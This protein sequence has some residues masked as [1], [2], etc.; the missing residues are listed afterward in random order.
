M[1]LLKNIFAR[2]WALWGIVT[3]IISF[4]IVY[5]PSMV[6]YLIPG[7]KGQTIFIYISR[8]WMNVWLTLIGCSVKIVG[9]ENVK[10]G[11]TYIF[12]CNHNTLLD[13]PLTCPYVPGANKTIAKM[14]FAK[15]PLFGWYYAK[16]SIL[17]DR[18]SDLSRRKGFDKMKSTLKEK[19]HVC[20]Y[21]EGTRNRTN[22]P[23][24]SFYDG[25]FKLSVDSKKAII[26]TILYNTKKAMPNDKFF[27]LLPTKLEMHFLP[28]I[29][30]DNLTIQELKKM[31]FNIMYEKVK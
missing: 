10:K 27:Y 31:V 29:Y 25:A 6:T 18:K 3:F 9:K 15:I 23:L 17:I 21:P 16:G 11:E 26:P 12:T 19:I 28:P 20:I 22:N 14:S 1:K 13:V 5:I 7:K 2:I 4:L 30:P 24:K 8:I